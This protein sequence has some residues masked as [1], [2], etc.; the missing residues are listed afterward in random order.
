MKTAFFRRIARS[1]AAGEFA[2]TTV[3]LF[4][5]V[6]V[7]RWLRD[8][9]SP[10][11]IPDL[12]LA[13]VVIG[14]VSGAVL[15]GLILTPLGR[16]TGGHMNPAVTVALWLM[17]AFPRRKVLP[18]ALAQLAGSV[19]GAGLAWL[20]WGNAV[21]FP[22]VDHGAIRP[23]PTWSADTVFAAEV[24]GM[25]AVIFVVGLLVHGGH[26]RLVPYA[27]GLSVGLVIAILGPLSGGSINPARQLGPAVFAGRST[28]L[29]VYLIAQILG[30]ALGAWL[31]HLLPSGPK[32]N[33]T[34]RSETSE[35]RH[36]RRHRSG[37]TATR[38]H[39]A[40]SG[41]SGDRAVP[42][43]HGG[44]PRAAAGSVGRPG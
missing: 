38:T 14:A 43:G 26:M 6:T 34:Q 3:L 8:P 13:L 35:Y 5:A 42:V 1:G 41:S 40:G 27:I 11:F 29:W 31:Y 19:A 2:L 25:A 16:R 7:V 37:R 28:D 9:G 20:A 12:N 32:R 44:R 18:Y 15:T 36:R 23:A 4:I 10:A 17:N 30:S 39:V 22:L 21:S 24:V 33:R